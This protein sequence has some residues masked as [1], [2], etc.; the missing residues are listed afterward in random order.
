MHLLAPLSFAGLPYFGFVRK[1]S[2][3]I[4]SLAVGLAISGAKFI[5]RKVDVGFL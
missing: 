3:L 5:D 1:T 4:V 2:I